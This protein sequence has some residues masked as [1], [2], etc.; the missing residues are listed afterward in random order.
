MRK[1]ASF[2]IFMFFRFS[3]FATLRQQRSRALSSLAKELTSSIKLGGGLSIHQFIRSCLTRPVH[4]YYMTNTVF[5][6]KGDFVTSPEISQIFGELIG[7]WFVKHFQDANDNRD[8]QIV[9]LGPGKGTLMY[10]VLQTLKQFPFVYDKI[11]AVSLVEA[12][13]LMQKEQEKKLSIFKDLKFEWFDRINEVEKCR[14]FY[15]AHEFFDALPIYQFKMTQD[16]FREILVDINDEIEGE[17][18]PVLA[19]HKTKPLLLLENQTQ[20]EKCKVDDIIQISPDTLDISS[21]IGS[22]ITEYG[23]AGLVIDYGQEQIRTDRL[24]GIKNHKFVSIFQ[25]VGSV[26]ISSDVEFEAIGL[27]VSKSGFLEINFRGKV[28]RTS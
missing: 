8:V 3:R 18:R 4:G 27:A 6:T 2:S 16:G 14:S 11:K 28:S 22:R 25:D 15:I 10:D 23:G 26:D 9:E 13:Q 20:Y 19:K 7:I 12:S 21:I 5:G 1:L 24:R 17:F